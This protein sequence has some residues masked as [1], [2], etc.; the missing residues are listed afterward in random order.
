MRAA[1]R[2][3]AR[4]LPRGI[5]VVIDRTSG[6]S[7]SKP[8]QQRSREAIS[9]GVITARIKVGLMADPVTAAYDIHVETFKGIV[10]LTGFV[11]TTTVRAEA[12]HVAQDVDGV[13]QVNDWL[14]IRNA[15]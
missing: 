11:E 10:E 7:R 13:Q 9:D 14:D 6:I 15:D 2:P 3:P 5:S 4:D 8:T 1:E 12:L